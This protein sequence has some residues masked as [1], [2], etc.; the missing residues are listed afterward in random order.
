M[1]KKSSIGSCDGGG[2]G[3]K[4]LPVKTCRTTS[5]LFRPGAKLIVHR[6][7]IMEG[8][9][10]SCS[11][12]STALYKTFQRPMLKRR[13]YGKNA[14]L[15]L[16]GSSLGP[17]RRMD[18][19]QKLMARAGRG[20]A[21]KLPEAKKNQTSD[22]TEESESEDEKE[23]DAPFEPL[24]VWKSPHQG[25]APKGLP[26]Q[27]YVTICQRFLEAPTFYGIPITF[28]INPSLFFD[29]SA[30]SHGLF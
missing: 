13:A 19:M 25:G 6:A 3:L 29:C 2:G 8:L 7:P 18:G 11:S 17:K 1:R 21:F 26:P 15:A 5:K 27:T 10:S 12:S 22:D 16:K 28:S 30:Q 23:E 4:C 9:S 24:E 20:L 14:E